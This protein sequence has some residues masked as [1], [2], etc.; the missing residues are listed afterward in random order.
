MEVYEKEVVYDHLS[1]IRLFLIQLYTIESKLLA[2]VF[3]EVGQ[4][5]EKGNVFHDVLEENHQ[6]YIYKNMFENVLNLQLGELET[7]FVKMGEPIPCTEYY[8]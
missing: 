7:L 6:Q 5:A 3:P 1:L 4:V 8:L 2:F